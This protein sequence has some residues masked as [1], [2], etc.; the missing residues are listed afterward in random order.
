MGRGPNGAISRRRIDRQS[1]GRRARP[2]LLRRAADLASGE[3]AS[4][5]IDDLDRLPETRQR[6]PRD[7]RHSVFRIRPTGSKRRGP[8][9]HHRKARRESA[10]AGRCRSRRVRGHARGSGAGIFRHSRR[11]FECRSGHDQMAEGAEAPRPRV[12]LARCR[13]RQAGAKIRQRHR[14]RH[15]H[16]RQ[17]SQERQPD[18]SDA[19]HRRCRRQKRAHGRRHDHDGPAR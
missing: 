8:N 12:R 14:R 1:R 11:S 7:G 16:H 3:R 4:D 19:N 15:L 2:G 9:A 13:Q 6:R 10:G 5:G 18:R 17:A